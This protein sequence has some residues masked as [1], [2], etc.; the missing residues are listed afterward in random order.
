MNCVCVNSHSSCSTAE[1]V[2]L[3]T[4]T[5][6]LMSTPLL[7]ISIVKG[8]VQF[9]K[10]CSSVV[11]IVKDPTAASRPG[12]KACLIYMWYVQNSQYS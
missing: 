4:S 9:K 11:V 3:T 6:Y 10:K 2:E 12:I 5:Q 7:V 1:E 8:A